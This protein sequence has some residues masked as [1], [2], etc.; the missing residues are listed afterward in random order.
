MNRSRTITL[1]AA[2]VSG[3]ISLFVLWQQ[4]RLNVARTE[5]DELRQRVTALTS[6]CEQ[7]A[8]LAAP[9]T[10][11]NSRLPQKEYFELMRLRGEL[12]LLRSQVQQQASQA[13]T[14][15]AQNATSDV[16]PGAGQPLT[17]GVSVRVSSGQTLV[18]GGWRTEPG[19][20]AFVFVTPVVDEKPDQPG[21]VVFRS[22]ILEMT[23]DVLQ[24]SGLS[25]FTT[26]A[27]DSSLAGLYSADH[28][29]TFRQAMQSL[30]GV[31][32][33]SQTLIAY[34]GGPARFRLG[35]PSSVN[36]PAGNTEAVIELVPQIAP[37]GEGVDL[38]VRA[39]LPRP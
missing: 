2:G 31:R 38:T 11:A 36:T 16:A 34:E 22:E 23:D 19:K 12:G 8:R 27:R 13:A 3:L 14:N 18:T 24:Q 35:G 21:R 37:G 25:D 1:I 15:A 30:E 32:S 39:E 20:R 33:D 5:R 28:A 9:V 17:A 10:Q 6:L 4:Q 29:R 7:H 26:D